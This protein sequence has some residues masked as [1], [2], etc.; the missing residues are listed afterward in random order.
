MVSV[1][2]SSPCIKGQSKLSLARRWEVLKMEVLKEGRRAL[3]SRGKMKRN[4][5]HPFSLTPSDTHEQ[6]KMS[7]YARTSHDGNSS[8]LFFMVASNKPMCQVNWLLIIAHFNCLDFH[9][10]SKILTLARLFYVLGNT[11][12]ATSTGRKDHICSGGGDLQSSDK[13]LKGIKR[14]NQITDRDFL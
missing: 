4:M 3:D 11:C 9:W 14:L 7:S 1:L 6:S 5:S 13:L 10:F 12:M 2:R 8:N